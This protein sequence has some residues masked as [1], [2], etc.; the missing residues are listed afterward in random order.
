MS[1]KLCR[2]QQILQEVWNTEPNKIF[3]LV[4]KVDHGTL[5]TGQSVKQ[6]EK[7][8]HEHV[9]GNMTHS[10]AESQAGLSEGIQEKFL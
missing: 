5:F 7:N 10:Q 1:R 9:S 6:N 2:V 8:H 4:E 3:S